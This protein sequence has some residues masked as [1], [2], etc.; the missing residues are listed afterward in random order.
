MDIYLSPFIPLNTSPKNCHV[1]PKYISVLTAETI[2]TYL[3]YDRKKELGANPF[4]VLPQSIIKLDP[5]AQRGLASQFDKN[6]LQQKKKIDEIADTLLGIGKFEKNRVFLGTLVWNIRPDDGSIE[7]FTEESKKSKEKKTKIKISAGVI[8]LPDSAH[9]HFG[10]A[11]AWRRYMGNKKNYEGFDEKATFSVEV[12]NLDFDG[13]CQLF[14]EL[15]RK[16]TRISTTKQQSVDTLTPAARLKLRILQ[17]DM[18]DITK[19]YDEKQV[20]SDEPFFYSNYE[21]TTNKITNHKLLTMNVFMTAINLMFSNEELLAAEKNGDLADE[22]SMYFVRF[23][24]TLRETIQVQI[25]FD[26]GAKPVKPFHNL[27]SERIGK[28]V[29]GVEDAS[30]DASEDASEK[31]IRSAFDDATKYAQVV[32]EADKTNSNPVIKAFAK[33]GGLIRRMPRWDLVLDQIQTNGFEKKDGRLFQGSNLDILER[34][35]ATFKKDGKINIQVNNQVVDLIYDY[36]VELAGL[37]NNSTILEVVNET[38]R[39]KP[40]KYVLILSRTGQTILEFEIAFWV[41]ADVEVEKSSIYVRVSNN[42]EWVRGNMTSTKQRPECKE[43]VKHD[44]QH[45]CYEKNNLQKY[46]AKFE[47]K[48]PVYDLS[49]LESF[50]INLKVNHPLINGKPGVHDVDISC[51]PFRKETIGD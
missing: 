33:L 26:D 9:R 13:E 11:E 41:G 5:T 29:E 43:L 51:Q 21:E 27:Y 16:N 37:Q 38:Q 22:F 46:M 23:F 10:I 14:D 34:K 4:V 39:T 48:F 25:D 35:I 28:I 31:V 19:H 50:L 1:V 15:N 32:R 47:I 8:Y 36:F 12:Y 6:L 30:D 18:G 20:I 40:D 24:F 3:I 44:V 2:A 7:V 17:A 42:R 45:P 49:N